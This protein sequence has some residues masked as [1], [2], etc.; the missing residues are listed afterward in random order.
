MS[1]PVSC[2]ISPHFFYRFLQHSSW[3]SQPDLLKRRQ[4]V[5]VCEVLFSFNLYRIRILNLRIYTCFGSICDPFTHEYFVFLA[6]EVRALSFSHIVNPMSFKVVPASFC[7]NTVTAPFA[8]KPHTFVDVSIFVYHSAFAMREVV[9]PHTIIS[10]SRLVEH[11]PSALF[12]VRVPISR[13]LPSQFVFG[14]GNPVCTLTVPFISLPTS[15]I[16]ITVGIMLYTEAVLFIIEPIAHVL[17]GADPFV[18]FLR[19]V[20]VE[21]LFLDMER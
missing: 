1:R 20:L 5:R 7:K 11:G 18:G 13:V 4:N 2:S 21:G 16:L 9:H 8:L 10:V 12:L 19:T 6:K 17:V 15:F 14:I 3:I